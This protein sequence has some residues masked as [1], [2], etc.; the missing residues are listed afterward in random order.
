MILFVF[1]IIVILWQWN[2][3]W[4]EIF[5][6]QICFYGSSTVTNYFLKFPLPNCRRTRPLLNKQILMIFTDLEW[7]TLSKPCQRKTEAC[8]WTPWMAKSQCMS[9]LLNLQMLIKLFLTKADFFLFKDV[10]KPWKIVVLKTKVN[11]YSHFFY[12]C[13]TY[14][15]FFVKLILIYLLTYLQVFIEWLESLQKLQNVCR[16]ASTRKSQKNSI[17]RIPWNGKAK[18]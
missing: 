9:M 11:I 2:S 16:P 5:F 14:L 15:F 4:F 3:Q 7:F 6:P 10:F 12:F 1:I 18:P 8:G 17:L 13:C